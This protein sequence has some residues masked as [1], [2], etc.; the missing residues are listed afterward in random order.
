MIMRTY[1]PQLVELLNSLE[2]EP[3]TPTLRTF[4]SIMDYVRDNREF[5]LIHKKEFEKIYPDAVNK[6]KL[7]PSG[8]ADLKAD[9]NDAYN[10]FKKLIC[11]QIK[12]QIKLWKENELRNAFEVV[13]KAPTDDQ[14]RKLEV[15]LK[16]ENLSAS[17]VE[18]WAKEFGS[19]YL[20][21]SA[22]RDYAEKQGYIISFSDFTD[23]DD[24]LSDINNA[25]DYLLEMINVIDQNDLSY[26]QMCF[27]GSDDNGNPYEGTL[28]AEYVKVLDRDV[29]FK[30]EQKIEVKRKDEDQDANEGS[31]PDGETVE[32]KPKVEDK[33]YLMPTK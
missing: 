31:S 8:L 17:E 3:I 9:F 30:G 1:Y 26:K 10:N 4:K 24:R 21:A 29:T 6:G 22:F 25:N 23:V 20:C 16:R 15:I 28:A 32:N 12:G 14:A 27:F 5:F 19:N 2:K 33:I 18:L 11:D 13:N 7:T